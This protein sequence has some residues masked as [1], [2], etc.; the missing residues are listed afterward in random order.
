MSWRWTL[1]INIPIG[2]LLIW[3]APR[4]LGESAPQRGRFDLLGALVETGGLVAVVYG[5]THAASHEWTSPT[6]IALLVAGVG[7]LV[8]FL[9]IESRVEHPLLPMRILADRNGP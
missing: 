6:T 4:F 3:L 5:L 7:L 1:F 9:V 8:A 2:I